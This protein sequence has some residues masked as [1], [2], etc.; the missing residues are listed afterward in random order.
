MTTKKLTSAEIR[1]TFLDYFSEHAHTVI[2]SA[3]LVPQDDPTLLFT[4]AGMNQFK[5]VFLGTGTRPYTRATDTQRCMRVA[6]KHNDLEDVGR[7]GTHHT[8]FEMLG[9]WSFG[10]YY[11]KEVITWGW[12]LLTEVFGL[13][14]SRL[15]VTVFKDDKGDLGLDEEAATYWRTATDIAP[16]HITFFG[17]KDNFWEMGETGPCGPCSEIHYDRGPESCDKQG[18]PGHVCKVNG[19][20]TRYTEIWNLVF[21]QY[22]RQ[23]NGMLEPLPAKH[24]D[25]GLGFERLVA[26]LQGHSSNYRTDLFW[27]IIEHVQSMTGQTDAEREANIIAYRVIADHI[28]AVT[29]LIG[30][31]VLPAN[32]GRGYVLRMILRRAVRFGRK[33]G[34]TTPFMHEL[35]GLVIKM[36]GDVFPELPTRTD[37]IKAT[38]LNEEKRFLRTL[39]QGLA[40]LDEVMAALKEKQTTFIPG[41]D[42]FFLHDTLG[43]PP[44]VTRDVAEENGFTI[45]K[46]GYDK[47]REAH[48]SDEGSEEME[49]DPHDLLYPILQD[50]MRAQ[51]CKS[52]GYDPYY[53]LS[54]KTCV[55]GM[56]RNDSID[57]SAVVGDTVE[58][59]LKHTCF[60]VESGG[61]VS[62]TGRI[63]GPGWEVVVEDTRRPIEGLVI[64]IGRVI[65]GAPAVGDPVTAEV[66]ASRRWDIMRNHTATHLLHR[67][68]REVLGSH[69]A[70]AGSLVAP[71]RL[72]FD[73][74]HDEPMTAE[75]RDRIERIVTQAILANYAV[76]SREEAYRDALQQGVIAL[77]GEKYGEVVR[78]L[79]VGGADAPFSQELCGGTHVNWTGDIGPFV[80][81]SE[82]G[83]G[84]GIRRIEATTGRGALQAHHGTRARLEQAGAL[85]NTQP[86]NVP[87]RIER[88]QEELRAAHK[89]IEQLKRKMARMDFQ[90]LLDNVVDIAGVPVL[91]AQVDA[92]D[93]NTLREMADW[94]RD[95]M[96]GGVIVL[97]AVID[98]KPMLIA[99][100]TQ[101]LAKERG[102]HAGNL[103]RDLAKMV[104][105]G[106]GGRPDMAQAGGRD[107]AKLPEALGEATALISKMIN[108]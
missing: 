80:I 16:D 45:D 9:N 54:V 26:L 85:L 65:Q 50:W 20:C 63:L 23:A 87:Q 3:S 49:V 89:E 29:F 34:F 64:H 71:E 84:A 47:I 56:I 8:F 104:G 24:V 55:S 59:V 1:Q 30:D 96:Q 74:N 99:A 15:W 25:T 97:G 4:N 19:D 93:V 105:G 62:D 88:L 90:S 108:T 69:V 86:D 35:A 36:M 66:D 81:L 92:P 100:T 58:L 67:A 76:T 43:L 95:K 11:K 48:S 27:P 106:G 52:L 39:D 40:R 72:R 68:L 77:F 102:I 6:G 38:I 37:F 101:A 31:G 28:R 2:P 22:N 79:R 46:A 73:Y 17:R 21:I 103:I 33:L 91:A 32:K 57:S 78:V 14:K 13:D 10:D 18:L 41:E 5:D 7:D 107:A 53:S 60:Y 61:Q 44:E 75:Q 94:F 98:G 70:Q 51:D 83:I 82:G 42:V 12:Y